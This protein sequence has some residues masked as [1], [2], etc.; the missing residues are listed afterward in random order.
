MIMMMIMILKTYGPRPPRGVAKNLSITFC[1]EMF[2]TNRRT[3]KQ[4]GWG[5]FVRARG[6]NFH[7]VITTDYPYG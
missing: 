5:R 1:F 6:I 2:D 7:Y 3:H 4:G